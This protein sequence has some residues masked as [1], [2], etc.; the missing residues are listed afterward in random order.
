LSKIC[1]N[2][3]GF[4]AIMEPYAD[5]VLTDSAALFGSGRRDSDAASGCRIGS[6]CV[7]SQKS[8]T[9]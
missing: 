9:L 4:A 8:E 5:A 3:Q 2:P 6:A 7:I 1:A